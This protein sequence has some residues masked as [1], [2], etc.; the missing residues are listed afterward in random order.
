MLIYIPTDIWRGLW[1]SSVEKY[2]IEGAF[3]TQGMNFRGSLNMTENNRKH[4]QLA[5]V[6]LSQNNAFQGSDISLLF[7]VSGSVN[8]QNRWQSHRNKHANKHCLNL[9]D[10]DLAKGRWKQWAVFL[11]FAGDK[12][13]AGGQLI[14]DDG[15]NLRQRPHCRLIYLTYHRMPEDLG[16][17]WLDI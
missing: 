12:T 1:W 3:L 17:Q 8:W 4:Q 2:L 14:P 15:R 7:L 13:P 16:W 11:T 5:L 6:D 10:M 9:V